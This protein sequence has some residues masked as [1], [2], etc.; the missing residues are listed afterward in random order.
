MAFLA[1]IAGAVG[2]GGLSGA[3]SLIGTLFSVAGGLMEASAA[4]KAADYQAKVAENNAKIAT[5]NANRASQ[6]AQEQQIQSDNEIAAFIGQQEAVQSASGL[7]TTGRSQLLTRKSAARLGRQDAAN[8]I[9]RG[10]QETRNFHQQSADFLNEANQ[11]RA[12]GRAAATRG[13]LG[14][15]SGLVSLVGNASPTKNAMYKRYGRD[16]WAGMR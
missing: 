7:S 14:A 4:R 11:A 13:V 2:G 1:P 16:P 12:S 10:N 15:A 6:T 3:A 8:I 5:E 9:A